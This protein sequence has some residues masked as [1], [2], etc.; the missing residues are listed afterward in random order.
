MTKQNIA[1]YGLCFFLDMHRELVINK[2]II[3]VIYGVIIKIA[4]TK[5]MPIFP[6]P[7]MPAGEGDD[8]PSEEKKAEIEKDIEMTTK[9]NAEAEVQNEEVNKIQA[10]VKINF[11]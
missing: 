11:R 7:E 3:E 5:L 2:E 8:A 4:R 1:D 6:L 9:H 10:K